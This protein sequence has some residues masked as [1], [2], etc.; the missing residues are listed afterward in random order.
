MLGD[1][2]TIAAISTA[3]GI[4]ALSIVRISGS[5]TSDI[6]KSSFVSSSTPPWESHKAHYGFW[7]D[8][9]SRNKLDEVLVLY[10]SPGKGFTGEEA[11]EIICHGGIEITNQVLS[12]ILTAGAR[13]ARPGEFTYRAVMNNKMDLAQ[14]ESVLEIIQAR[15]PQAAALA[16]KNI[17]GALSEKL[18]V[19]EK[20]ILFLVANLEASIDFTTEDIQPVS[21][22]EMAQRLN[23]VIENVEALL[24]TYLPS[25]ITKFGLRTVLAGKPNGG[26]S[27]LLNSLLGVSRSI[28]DENPGT[29]RDTI[30]AE[31]NLAGQFFCL[32]D[33][34][35][36]RS[37]ETKV[38]GHGVLRAY[39]EIKSAD[40]IIYV[41]DGA[42]GL[43]NEDVEE[44]EKIENSRTLICFNKSDLN[45]ST[46]GSLSRFGLENY[47]SV[48]SS[49]LTAQ[50]TESLISALLKLAQERSFGGE[51]DGAISTQRQSENLEK[52]L[53]SLNEAKVSLG[54]DL[55]PDLISF[56]LREALS[57]IENTLGKNVGEDVMDRV[58]KEFCIGK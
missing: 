22:K 16:L 42:Q 38:E 1:Q 57:A 51:V 33:T 3:K 56:S 48:I 29:T 9:G 2:E 55:S 14:A 36:L 37:A 20:E 45:S 34:A 5:Q 47:K 12:A 6:L 30:E 39:D 7:C 18:K 54:K 44:I 23:P 4:G 11:A 28:V 52:A 49:A 24:K 21:F 43:S 26:K 27:S 32:V 46:P 13:L 50:G 8:P 40:I 19:F 17:Q 25:R 31:I 10:F 35:G 53:L 15:T 41:V 58:F